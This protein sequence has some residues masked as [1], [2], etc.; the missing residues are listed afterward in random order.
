MDLV[1]VNSVISRAEVLTKLRQQVQR[2]LNFVDFSVWVFWASISIISRLRK[3]VCI[4]FSNSEDRSTVGFGHLLFIAK[5]RKR[6][7]TRPFIK[8][9]RVVEDVTIEQL[10]HRNLLFEK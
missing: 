7:I 1:E 5:S 3:H 6:M 8:V 2:I 4:L 9:K 10:P